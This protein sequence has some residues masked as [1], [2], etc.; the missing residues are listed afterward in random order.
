MSKHSC[1]YFFF[2]NPIFEIHT[3]MC[4]ETSFP[5]GIYRVNN[6]AP[7]GSGSDVW[8]HNVPSRNNDFIQ[9]LRN[10]CDR[11]SHRLTWP[12][13]P[14]CPVWAEVCLDSLTQPIL[15]RISEEVSVETGWQKNH[16]IPVLYDSSPAEIK[17]RSTAPVQIISDGWAE[18]L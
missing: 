1:T 10:P 4:R 16:I 9:Q 17:I 3:Q 7:M 6:A 11:T 14:G 2:K 15:W 5:F 12:V 18:L 13:T 8:K